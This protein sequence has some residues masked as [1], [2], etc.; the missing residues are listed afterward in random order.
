MMSFLHKHQA[1]E[2]I[3]DPSSQ[4]LSMSRFLLGVIV[5]IYWPVNVLCDV[6]LKVAHAGKMENWP[7]LGVMTGAIAGIY[8]FN[9]TA[10]S[11]QRGGIPG[12]WMEGGDVPYIPPGP[13][14]AKAKPAPP[15]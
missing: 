5:L 1:V 3:V 8:W 4:Q 15:Q 11:W 2:A 9:S 14:P 10:G 7:V 13:P 12:S 6:L